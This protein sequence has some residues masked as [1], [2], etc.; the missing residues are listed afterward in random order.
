MIDD[1]LESH[2]LAA[3]QP[4]RVRAMLAR[5]H[6]LAEGEVSMEAAGLCTTGSDGCLANL[7]A[8]RWAWGPWMD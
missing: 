4:E 6:E 5:Y 1:P 3:E 2:D 7:R 8:G